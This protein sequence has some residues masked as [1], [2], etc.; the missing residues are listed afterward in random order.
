MTADATIPVARSAWMP[1]H[2]YVAYTILGMALH[3]AMGGPQLLHLPWLGMALLAP[4]GALTIWAARTFGAAGTTLKPCER[5]HTLVVT[6]PYRF[7]RNPMY[8]GLITMLLGVALCLATPAI[9]LAALALPLT[10]QLRFVRHEERALAAS[11]GEPY[12]RYRRS[13]RRWI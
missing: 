3:F 1:P 13:V 6:G 10:L 9:W 4:G 7:T 12:D 8:L 5:T 11:L 2:Y